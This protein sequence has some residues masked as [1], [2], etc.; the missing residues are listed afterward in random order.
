M[1]ISLS[2]RAVCASGAA[3]LCVLLGT[4]PALSHATPSGMGLRVG[5]VQGRAQWA[6]SRGWTRDA[7]AWQAHDGWSRS[8][9]W[10]GWGFNAWRW[11]GWGRNWHSS[12]AGLYGFGY[13]ASLDASGPPLGAAG[14]SVVIRAPSINV[15]PPAE[16]AS[17]DRGVGGCVI[18]KLIYDGDGKYVGEQQTPEC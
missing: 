12:Q 7:W 9:R 16:P 17:F 18:H 3:M 1:R 4:P 10:N 11:R 8:S 15:D 2:M 6:G 13:G 5:T 14:L